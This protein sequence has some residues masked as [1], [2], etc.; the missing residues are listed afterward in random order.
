MP[1]APARLPRR[2]SCS[3]PAPNDPRTQQ[4]TRKKTR[5]SPSRSTTA[6]PAREAAQPA[7]HGW[8]GTAGATRRLS[9][10]PAPAPT[11]WPNSSPTSSPRPTPA[12]PDRRAKLSVNGQSRGHDDL[13]R[14]RR[15]G[16]LT[17]TIRSNNITVGRHERGTRWSHARGG[18]VV[19]SWWRVTWRRPGAT[20]DAGG[21]AWHSTCALLAPLTRLRP[22]ASGGHSHP[23]SPS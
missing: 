15:P 10:T 19:P 9:D 17:S 8:C 2:H 3:R 16:C 11:V 5:P 1:T 14:S 6:P 4:E 13:L 7:R 18:R 21:R 23:A 12:I 22:S 20:L